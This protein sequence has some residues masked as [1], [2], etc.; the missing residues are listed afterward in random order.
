MRIIKNQMKF[1]YKKNSNKN[2]FN[3]D[4]KKIDEL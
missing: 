2:D 3:I 4:K 1:K